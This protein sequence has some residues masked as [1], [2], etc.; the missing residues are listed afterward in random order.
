M[1]IV[2]QKYQYVDMVSYFI[3]YLQHSILQET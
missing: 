2:S 3:S 1:L